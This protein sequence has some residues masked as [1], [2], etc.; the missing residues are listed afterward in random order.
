MRISLKI[1]LLVSLLSITFFQGSFAQQINEDQ[2]KNWLKISTH[3]EEFYLVVDNDYLNSYHLAS[4]DSI[5]LPVGGHELR[6]I[7]RNIDDYVSYVDIRKDQTSVK[8]VT[9][10]SF[11]TSPNSSYSIIESQQN[12]SIQTDPNSSIYIDGDFKGTQYSELFLNP[13]KYELYI[14]SPEYGS[15]TKTL[16]VGHTEYTSVAQYNQNINPIP[17][18]QRFIPGVSYLANGQRNKAVG[19][20]VGLV[21]LVGSALYFNSEYNDK[22][23]LFEQL[24][25]EYLGAD[26]PERAIALR[27]EAQNTL[28][29][30]DKLNT[31]ITAFTLGAVAW[32]VITTLDGLRKPKKGYPGNIRFEPQFSFKGNSSPYPKVSLNIDF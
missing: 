4:G 30:M 17:T 24:N 19:T 11:K 7:W 18:F 32:Y 25:I 6:I 27:K 12:V 22:N 5:L 1:F 10:T 15:L 16:S 3:L 28:Q 20:Y 9:F 23:D 29:E 26:T 2:E 8:R 14:E 13:G 31:R 21:A